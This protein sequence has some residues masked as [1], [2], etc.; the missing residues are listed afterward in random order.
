[1]LDTQ[2]EWAV[3]LRTTNS[4]PEIGILLPFCNNKAILPFWR[5]ALIFCRIFALCLIVLKREA[6]FSLQTPRH[7]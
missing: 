6:S 5:T 1:M 2:N 4:A 7:D 3:T